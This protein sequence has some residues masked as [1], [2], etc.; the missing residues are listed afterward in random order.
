[1]IWDCCMLRD[2]LDMLECRLTEMEDYDVI[3]VIVES[4]VTH[5]GEPKPLYFASESGDRF[6]RWRDRICSVAVGQAAFPL[7]AGPW[8]REH[9]QRD[10]AG[11]VLGAA[12]PDDLVLISDVD[13]IPSVAVLAANPDPV[14]TLSMRILA[15]AANWL[16]PAPQHHGVVARAGWL[17][18]KSLGAVRDGRH[19]YPVL[20]NAGWH[21]TWFGGPEA[22][23]AKA[24]GTC[25]LELYEHIV[26]ANKAG[27][28]YER[29]QTWFGGDC[30]KVVP[31][32]TWPRYIREG[33]CPASW[34]PGKEPS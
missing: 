16:V 33:R 32:G 23:A 24:E 9:V 3:H 6:K 7:G 21:L 26:A 25:H 34:L 13:E 30:Q 5:R 1:M 14:L 12:K 17:A 8:D 11:L 10:M 18:G 2:E 4:F 22:I 20:E 28:L 31:D 15:F 19:S 29:G 27:L